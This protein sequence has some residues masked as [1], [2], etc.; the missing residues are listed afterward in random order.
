[1][2]NSKDYVLLHDFGYGKQPQQEKLNKLKLRNLEDL[3]IYVNDV[4]ECAFVATW[5][6]NIIEF[7]PDKQKTKIE[8]DSLFGKI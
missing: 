5:H 7:E 3:K 4:M 2:L 6:D 1:M 8:I